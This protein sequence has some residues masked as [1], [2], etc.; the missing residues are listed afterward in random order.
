MGNIAYLF[1]EVKVS[2]AV[3]LEFNEK[4]LE[5]D[6]LKGNIALHVLESLKRQKVLD[7]VVYTTD[8][9]E[10]INLI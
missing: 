9:G 10:R 7:I 8:D 2:E 6:L 1:N 3:T 5:D 4:S